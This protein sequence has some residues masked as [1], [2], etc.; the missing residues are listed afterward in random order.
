MN[1]AQFLAQLTQIVSVAPGDLVYHL[2]VLFAIEATLMIAIGE[3]RRANW[4]RGTL[5]VMLAAG[6]LLLARSLLV[7]VA[8]LSAARVANSAWIAPPLERL[9]SVAS[10]GLLIWAFLPLMKDY[11]QAGLVLVVVN[12]F[13]ALVL[14][15][16]LAPQWYAE[17]QLAQKAYN[18]TPAD[19]VWNVWAAAL[20]LFALVAAVV[21]RRGQWGILAAVFSLLFLGHVL[22]LLM[23]EPQA[24]IAG[25]VRLAE[26]CAYPVLAG[27]MMRRAAEPEETA[28]PVP[29]QSTTTPWTV[30][31][32][33]QRVGDSPNVKVALQRAGVAISNVLNADV[34]AIGLWDEVGNT[35][36]LAAVCRTGEPA[37]S[38]PSFDL[39]SQAPIQSAVSRQRGIMVNTDRE[40]QRAA[41]SALMGGAAGPLWVQPLV[42]Q[43]ATMGILV[44]GRPHST[45]G[46]TASDIQTLGGL[47]NVLAAALSAARKATALSQQ[48][49]ELTRLAHERE[50]ALAQAQAQ[51]QS[52]RDEL[53][54]LGAQIEAQRR[55]ARSADP[56]VRQRE[57]LRPTPPVPAKASLPAELPGGSAHLPRRA[58]FFEQ[59]AA[60]L[61]QFDEAR[62][63]LAISSGDQNALS[64]LVQAA[65]TLKDTSATMG[66]NTLAKLAGT[67][68]EVLRRAQAERQPATPDMLA[69]VG[70]SASALR[71]LLADVQ[72]DRPPSL[73]ATPLLNRL[74]LSLEARGAEEMTGT[75]AGAQM[76]LA[77]VKIRRDTPLKPARAMM[78][79]MQIKRVGQ[80]VACQPVEADLRSGGF[81]DEFT[82]RFTT[83]SKPEV[84][85]AALSAIPDVTSVDVSAVR[86]D[87]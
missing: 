76:L 2:V 33:C 63:R 82:V 6:G 49:D 69:L 27:L 51:L 22:H 41:L 87:G 74:A 71:A 77:K 59:A 13:G 70:E 46:W 15:A 31:E 73:D 39:D 53:R 54:Q 17:S 40:A 8:L 36:E 32:T 1:A 18:A 48:V 81:E 37:R 47:C 45:S 30:I 60:Q 11:P 68:A 65:H 10:L 84:V 86:T 35:V 3:G 61:E 85:R 20:A 78:V 44:A 19:W 72:A 83:T 21:R 64:A 67:L 26:L 25:W 34:L 14:Y 29:A 43:R 57:A 56:V 12:L 28:R 79:L 42:H 52:S 5:Q 50:T 62:G 7:I 75:L 38:G 66:Y 16:V 80:I 23:A 58:N 4:Q 9:V 24:H 55:G